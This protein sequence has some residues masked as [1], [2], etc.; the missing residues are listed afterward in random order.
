MDLYYKHSGRFT[1]FGVLVGLFAGIAASL[2][3]AWLYSYGI[4]QMP[5]IKL[6]ALS[7]L[8][9]ALAIGWST[10]LGLVW[11]KVRNN[12]VAALCGLFVSAL[13][14]YASWVFWLLQLSG[15][16]RYAVKDFALL[17]QPATVSKIVQE[18]MRIG[19]WGTSGSENTHG[20]E[21]AAIWCIEALTVV[22][23]GL[24]TTVA[25][26]KRKP[27]CDNCDCWCD[28]SER[29]VF[30]PSIFGQ[31][32][33]L[34]LE[35][36]DFSFV[37]KLVPTSEKFAHVRFDLFSCS[38]CNML[39]TISVNQLLV[40]PAKSRWRQ[41]KAERKELLSLMMVTPEE[42]ALIRRAAIGVGSPPSVAAS[43]AAAAK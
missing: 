20:A 3:L 6:R 8:F 43:K 15:I 26:L 16:S 32:L 1:P 19:T 40:Q 13:A 21:L 42:A 33:K 4:I 38:T 9:F 17:F 29:L 34:R 23:V 5:Y 30:F 2:P 25:V 28:R 18:V 27:F 7:T 41:A 14:L 11:G 10:A 36:R 37:E 39:N 24:L 31:H 35:A 12:A 22:G